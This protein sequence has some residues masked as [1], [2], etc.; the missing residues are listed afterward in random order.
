MVKPSSAIRH[1]PGPRK[2]FTI[3]TT[4]QEI[5]SYHPRF[6]NGFAP[7]PMWWPAYI[8]MKAVEVATE[9]L[10]KEIDVGCTKS[11]MRNNL[12][13]EWIYDDPALKDKWNPKYEAETVDWLRKKLF[14]LTY[15]GVKAGRIARSPAKRQ[16]P[17]PNNVDTS[18]LDD[19]AS[20]HQ[21]NMTMTVAETPE[22]HQAS[23]AVDAN[24][25]TPATYTVPAAVMHASV[26]AAP[27]FVRV[28]HFDVN[29]HLRLSQQGGIFLHAVDTTLEQLRALIAADVHEGT[30][31]ARLGDE[32][33]VAYRYRDKV[34]IIKNDVRMKTWLQIRSSE[35]PVMI[36]QRRANELDF[37]QCINT[38]YEN[39]SVGSN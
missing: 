20:E 31:P 22:H 36:I 14:N 28:E 30:G 18:I 6:S 25:F 17:Q 27:G 10:D 38:I 8:K 9:A 32:Y 35:D 3:S 5:L 2:L 33:A 39:T 37:E 11:E 26:P 12:V 21:G 23:T 7:G 19:T 13:R 15:N 1:E 29:G 24:T 34:Y 4:I 16:R